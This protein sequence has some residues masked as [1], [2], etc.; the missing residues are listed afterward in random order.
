MIQTSLGVATLALSRVGAFSVTAGVIDAEV[1]N[2]DGSVDT[3]HLV[4]IPVSQTDGSITWN[5]SGG[6]GMPPAYVPKR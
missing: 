4:M 2:I 6:A 1:Q 5:W 3:R